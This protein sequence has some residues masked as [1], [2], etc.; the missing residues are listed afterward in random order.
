[1]S[2]GQETGEDENSVTLGIVYI[3]SG[4]PKI[5][6]PFTIPTEIIKP[7]GV[8]VDYQWKIADSHGGSYT[9]IPGATSNT[10]TPVAADLGKYLQLDI[11]R[12]DNYLEYIIITFGSQIAP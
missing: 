9:S 12:K 1:M 5:G 7:V 10:Y 6:K 2:R 3:P 4:A 8:T 11:R